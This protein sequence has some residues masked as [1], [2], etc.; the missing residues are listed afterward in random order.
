MVREHPLIVSYFGRWEVQGHLVTRWELGDGTLESLLQEKL[1]TKSCGLSRDILLG[2]VRY[3]SGYMWQIASVLDFLLPPGEKTGTR[4]RDIKPANLVLFSGGY[5]K[6]GDLGLAKWVDGPLSSSGDSFIGGTPGY[7]PPESYKGRPDETW[8]LYSLAATYVRLRTGQ[9]PFGEKANEILRRQDDCEFVTDGLERDEMESLRRVLTPDPAKRPRDGA[10][11]FLESMQGRR[12]V[13]LPSR[14]KPG[15]NL[16]D[17]M[18]FVDAG[19]FQMGS[20]DEEQERGPNERRHLVR[21][22]RPFYAGVC[23]VT[24]RQFE[25][26]A[27]ANPAYETGAERHGEGGYVWRQDKYVLT[28]GANWRKPGFQQKPDYPVV[29]VSWNACQAY[30]EWLS[31]KEGEEFRLLTEAEWEY[32]C[33]GETKSYKVFGTGNGKSLDASQANFDGRSPYGLRIAGTALGQT[34]EVGKYALT[35]WGVKDMHGNVWE[36]CRDYFAD[37]YYRVSPTDDPPGPS[38]GDTRVLRGGGWESPGALCRSACR[39]HAEPSHR[40]NTVGF[41]VMRVIN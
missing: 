21:V 5:V 27:K 19:E 36:W 13:S 10:L 4:H 3:P 25:E 32:V 31:D 40:F 7:M 14:P 23:P 30:C 26:F 24:V 39:H 28:P 8:D 12:S 9:E 41:R 1:R 38:K 2:E 18:V 15:S 20:P 17:Q 29:L 35:G 16:D 37:D 22:A 11:A 6:L 33:R 34:C